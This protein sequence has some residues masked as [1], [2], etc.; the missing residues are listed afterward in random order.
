[1]K[2]EPVNDFPW[3]RS[4]T[5]S[6]VSKNLLVANPIDEQYKREITVYQ[7][8]LYPF[9]QNVAF[10]ETKQG[11]D[12]MGAIATPLSNAT[13]DKQLTQQVPIQLDDTFVLSE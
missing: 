13:F 9:P 2:K 4:P 6:K 12:R 5:K 1:M 11:L 3:K 10:V 8:P 7:I